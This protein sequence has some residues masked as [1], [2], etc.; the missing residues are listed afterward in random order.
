MNRDQG[1]TTR[2]STMQ[3][4]IKQAKKLSGQ[5]FCVYT[6]DQQLY[7]IALTEMWNTPE[8]SKD[9]YLRLGGMH[10]LMSYIGSIGALIGHEIGPIP[11][12]NLIELHYCGF[13]D[14]V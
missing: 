6:T 1:H 14:A 7:R 13:S 9:F 2:P 8:L 11:S 10:F 5:E 4:S 12:F 3:T